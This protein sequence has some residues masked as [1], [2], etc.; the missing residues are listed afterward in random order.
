MATTKLSS[1]KKNAKYTFY[2]FSNFI[3]FDWK[4][5]DNTIC[6][7][8]RIVELGISTTDIR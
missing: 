8:R 3:M 2:L 4:N 6:S 7:G 5:R 1:K